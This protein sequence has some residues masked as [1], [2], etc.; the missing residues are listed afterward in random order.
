MTVG[1]N[2][3]QMGTIRC[4]PDLA[5]TSVTVGVPGIGFAASMSEPLASPSRIPKIADHKLIEKSSTGIFCMEACVVKQ[6]FAV[7]L[8][9]RLKRMGV[10]GL[11]VDRIGE[12]LPRGLPT[13]S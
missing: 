13:P 12:K 1:L 8:S 5:T 3:R 6:R 7:G 10:T 9:G 11:G 2:G 4:S